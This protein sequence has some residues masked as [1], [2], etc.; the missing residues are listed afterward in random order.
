M[1]EA[2]H[3]SESPFLELLGTRVEEWRE[4]YVRIALDLRPHHLNRAGVV[5]GGVLTTLF[6][7]AGSFSGLYCT[8]AGNRRYGVTLSLT[9]NFVAQCGGGRLTAIGRPRAGPAH[10]LHPDRSA[11]RDGRGARDRHQRASL[12]QRQREPGGRSAALARGLILPVYCCTMPPA[13]YREGPAAARAAAVPPSMKA[14]ARAA[15]SSVSVQSCRQTASEADSSGSPMP[16]EN[17]S[18]VI[19]PS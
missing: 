9:A 11:R 14:R 12:S 8:V 19:V 10:L 13:L 3:E 4:G 1:A 6:D 16:A 2:R 15:R 7:H 18:K 17:A 5:H